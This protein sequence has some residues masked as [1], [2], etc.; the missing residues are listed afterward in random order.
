MNDQKQASE[1]FRSDIAAAINRYSMENAS[2][3]PDFILADFLDECLSAFSR[4][5][6]RRDEWYGERQTAPVEIEAKP[7]LP[8]HQQRVVDE[9]RDLDERAG[10]LLAFFDTVVFSTLDPAEQHRMRTQHV[11]MKTYSEILGERIAAF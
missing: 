7:S 9:K 6:K 10:K 3:T 2:N 5:A 1:P 11:A 8:P 4:A